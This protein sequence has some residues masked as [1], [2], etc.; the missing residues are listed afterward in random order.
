MS[1]VE[2][3]TLKTHCDIAWLTLKI[4]RDALWFY[5]LGRLMK[6]ITEFLFDVFVTAG[7]LG[8]NFSRFAFFF[9]FLPL[10]VN[11]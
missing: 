8:T 10:S 7:S 4:H 6:G 9:F 5:H 11:S 3:L 1:F 2:C